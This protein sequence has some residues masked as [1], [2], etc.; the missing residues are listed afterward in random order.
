LL[1]VR[2]NGLQ[3]GDNALLKLGRIHVHDLSQFR[4]A[5]SGGGELR[6]IGISI[7]DC[8]IAHIYIEP[9]IE[10]Q[11]ESCQIVR[12]GKIVTQT[13]GGNLQSQ[14]AS[15][16]I[17]SISGYIARQYRCF[18]RTKPSSKE[19]CRIF[20]SSEQIECLTKDL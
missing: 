7:Y 5:I 20:T 12:N 15:S 17:T 1:F 8:R 19:T 3:I 18:R 6:A 4:L 16:R 13:I 9:N 11:L 14:T 2:R 10:A